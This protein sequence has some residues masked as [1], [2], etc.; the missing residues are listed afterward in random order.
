MVSVLCM[1]VEPETLAQ[2]Q[3]YRRPPI[4]HEADSSAHLIAALE[5]DPTATEVVIL[6]KGVDDP[7]RLVHHVHALD[8][9]LAVMMLA[10]VAAAENL[11]AG[12]LF[13]P[14]LRGDVT[15]ACATDV[16]SLSNAIEEAAR[17][18]QKRRI[19]RT[20]NMASVA[21]LEGAAVELPTTA[22]F[23]VRLLDHSPA[24]IV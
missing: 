3:R 8:E 24:G 7:L 23:L 11:R 12:R 6:G 18:T 13:V 4:L 15:C 16:E 10:S 21:H 22:P 1:D 20:M 14:S 2:L 19:F 5:H 9:D 17:R